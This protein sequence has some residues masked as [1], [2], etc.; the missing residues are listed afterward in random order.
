MQ[1]LK[2]KYLFH[3]SH[4]K[5]LFTLH[6]IVLERQSKHNIGVYQVCGRYSCLNAESHLLTVE[7]RSH[8]K[9]H[10]VTALLYFM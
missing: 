4:E 7:A 9:S 6:A 1:K 2:K 8:D 5:K 3:K 10:L